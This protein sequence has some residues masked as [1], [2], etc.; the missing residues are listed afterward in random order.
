MPINQASPERQDRRRTE[1]CEEAS[2]EPGRAGHDH[3]APVAD[4]V[5]ERRGRDVAEHLAHTEQREHESGHAR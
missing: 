2:A 5:G 3:R 1:K 4:P